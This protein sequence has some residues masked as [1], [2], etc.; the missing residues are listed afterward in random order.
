MKEVKKGE[1]G[2]DSFL[3]LGMLVEYKESYS[4]THDDDTTTCSM[5]HIGSSDP[6]R[7]F[8]SIQFRFLLYALQPGNYSLGKYLCSVRVE[9]RGE[10]LL[11]RWDGMVILCTVQY[12][13][14]NTGITIHKRTVLYITVRLNGY[15]A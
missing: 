15:C 2:L 7:C 1:N 4:L 10:A 12:S 3:R 9:R 6:F 14:V 8:W 5:N 11:L 13:T